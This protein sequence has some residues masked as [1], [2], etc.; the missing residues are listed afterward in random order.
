MKCVRGS[1]RLKLT[2]WLTVAD[3]YSEDARYID[4]MIG[5]FSS[6]TQQLF[7]T[8]QTMASHLDEIATVSQQSATHTSQMALEVVEINLLTL[9]IA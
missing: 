9:V 3:S 4:E 5:D 7:T 8:I 2:V 6:T 1:L